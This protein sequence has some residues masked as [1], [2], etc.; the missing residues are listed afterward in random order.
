VSQIE[1][2]IVRT[3]RRLSGTSISVGPRGVVVR[4]PFWVPVWVIKNFIEE[5]K[6]W[7]EQQLKKFP[8]VSK[9]ERLYQDGENVYFLGEKLTL[10]VTETENITRTQV[11]HEEQIIRIVISGH[12]VGDKRNQE[13][14]KSLTSWFLEK[15]V[16]HITDKANIFSERLGVNYRKI[17][18]KNV[19][20]IWGSCSSKNNLNFNRHLIMAPHEVIDYVVIHEVCH[21]VHRDHSSRFWALVRSLDPEYKTHRLWLRQ[22]RNLLAF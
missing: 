19:S 1:Y 8:Q 15:G 18:L 5:K 6:D 17:T 12:I 16:E 13:V 22:N 7:I 10:K 4:A 20:S 11:I 2:S 21:L 9:K 14:K 3:Q